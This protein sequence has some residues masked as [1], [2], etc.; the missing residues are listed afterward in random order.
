MTKALLLALLLLSGCNTIAGFGRDIT[1]G[2]ERVGQL[3]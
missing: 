3:F 1:G 2:A